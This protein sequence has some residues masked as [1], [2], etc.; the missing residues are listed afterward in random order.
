[1]K[2]LFYKKLLT[3]QVECGIIYK[4]DLYA[5]VAQLVEHLTFNQGVR[6]SSSRRSTNRKR[7][8]CGAFFYWFLCTNPVAIGEGFVILPRPSPWESCQTEQNS[9]RILQLNC[10]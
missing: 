1:M 9:R 7:H 6:D 8:P 10:F 2:Q 3:N 5:P 4:H